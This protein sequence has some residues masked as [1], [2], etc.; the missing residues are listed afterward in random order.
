MGVAMEHLRLDSLLVICP[1]N[2]QA[3]LAP[4][5]E[6]MGIETFATLSRP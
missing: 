5:V 2:V 4:G 3:P 6:V 1:G